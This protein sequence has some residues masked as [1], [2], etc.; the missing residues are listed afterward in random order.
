MAT[1][2]KRGKQW[3]YRIR[4]VDPFTGKKAEHSKSGFKTK[5]EAEYAASVA[6]ID[7]KD[8]NVKNNPNILFKDYADHWFEL[9]K[10]TVKETS[11]RSRKQYLKTLK[12]TMGQLKL[13]DLTDN[14]YQKKLNE[15]SKKYKKNSLLSINQIAQMVAKQAVKD[16][17]FKYNPIANVKIPHYEDSEEKIKHWDLIDINKFDKYVKSEITKKRKPCNAYIS[18][19]KQRDLALYYL[20][21]YGGL[22]IGEACSLYVNDYYPLTKEINISKTL[23]SS[24]GNQV[25][26][27][28][29][30]FPP[31]TKSAYRSVPLPEIAYKQIEKWIGLRDTYTSLFP[32]IY[33][34]SS[35]LFCKKDGT[36][37]TPRDV[38]TKFNV[39]IQKNDLPKITL[40]GL[41]HT[42][43]ALQIQAGIDPKS[44]QLL[45]GHSNVQ[46]TL[47]I[48]AH[49][50]GDKRKE[51]IE[52]FDL[53]LK[54]F[55][56]GAKAGQAKKTMN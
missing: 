38:R 28:Y 22:R 34:K 9:Y 1:F 49:I 51:T 14:L 46:T 33:K 2:R 8:G 48:Y 36:P 35:F 12:S 16:R 17:Y 55:D 31:K 45:L 25:K 43:T 54:K 27:S 19:E 30:I 37:L 44:L 39:I 41:R 6:F 11:L 47:N 15:L 40:H 13:K 20:L 26:N 50:T 3:E 7:V 42:Y 52:Q 18:L 24:E 5:A 32:N 10:R 29:K 23:G 53:M 21:I 4:Y 56:G